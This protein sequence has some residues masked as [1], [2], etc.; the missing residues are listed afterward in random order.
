M[1]FKYSKVPSN[2]EIQWFL[3][4][5]RVAVYIQSLPDMLQPTHPFLAPVYFRPIK[6]TQIFPTAGAKLQKDLPSRSEI[7]KKYTWIKNHIW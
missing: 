6:G 4:F 3:W 5:A 2:L 1:F 7:D